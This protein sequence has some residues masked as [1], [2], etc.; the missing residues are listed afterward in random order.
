MLS[1]KGGRPHA[2]APGAASRALHGRVRRRLGRHDRCRQGHPRPTG[3]HPRP[4][5]PA[6]RRHGLGRRPGRLL[7]ALADRRRPN[8][9]RVRGLLRG[10][11]H[12][13]VGRRPDGRPPTGPP[14]R[15]QR[16]L[17]DGRHG[18]HRPGRGGLG[19]A[20]SGHRRGGPRAHHV[21]ELRRCHQ[22]LR[23]PTRRRG[24][25]L[26][27]RPRRAH[28]G[29]RPRRARPVLPR[30]APGSQ[31]RLRARLRRGRHA[32]VEPT[33]GPGRF[34]RLRGQGIHVPAVEGALLGAP[35]FSA[36]ARR[37]LPGRAPRGAGARPPRVCARGG[38]AG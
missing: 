22:G 9:G 7:R 26:L 35:A 10:A 11:L 18:R 1:L 31:H 32:S 37:R 23:G 33:P 14:P 6:R 21:H 24:L 4:P 25:H 12:G 17:L 3:V 29:A 28:L 20:G 15:P 2:Q 19:R 34:D 5:L 8:R 16:R 38:G 13:G 30:P 36:R 27:Q